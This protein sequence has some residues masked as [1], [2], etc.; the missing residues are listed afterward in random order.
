MPRR[1]APLPPALA[2]RVFTRREALDRLSLS[3]DRLRSLDLRQVT[4]GAH[5]AVV[6]VDVE[7]GL[8]KVVRLD[9]AQD[10]GRAVN[11]E[12]VRGQIQGG[13]AQGLGLAV[14]SRPDVVVLDLGLPDIDGI[15]LA[16]RG[17][18]AA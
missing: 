13:S 10:V 5:R 11:P 7:L 1:P 8:V 3:S 9:C 17:A 15:E 18:M 6:D 14:D 16:L 4:H 2:G 12:A